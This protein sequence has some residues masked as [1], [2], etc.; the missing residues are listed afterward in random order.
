MWPVLGAGV[1]VLTVSVTPLSDD[2]AR[3]IS[4]LAV[5]PDGAPW[6]VSE[7]QRPR[8]LQLSADGVIVAR[9]PV[10]RT[11][12]GFDLESVDWLEPGLLV[13][14]AE[15]PL[16][17]QAAVLLATWDG[18]RAEVVRIWRSG[19]GGLSGAVAINEGFEGICASDDLIAVAGETPMVTDTGSVAPLYLIRRDGLDWHRPTVDAVVY[20]PLPEG[21]SISALDCGADGEITAVVR[22]R[23]GGQPMRGL[24]RYTV[25]APVVEHLDLG[26]AVSAHNLEGLISAPGGWRAISDAPAGV[27]AWVDIRLR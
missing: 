14:G 1:G 5:G 22:G 18:Q 6:A 26:A 21:G 20:L 16:R 25:G 9:H 15:H 12:W 11:P 10:S 7:R 3:G 4:G 19:R 24:L 23:P 13:L 27:A 8:L 17:G 2:S